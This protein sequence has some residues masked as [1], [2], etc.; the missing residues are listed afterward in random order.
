MRPP[1]E[2]TEEG[3]MPLDGPA[4][5]PL[6]VTPGTSPPSDPAGGSR[7]QV[8]DCRVAGRSP[9]MVSD[10]EHPGYCPNCG[11]SWALD[12]GSG[13]AQPVE[14]EASR[15]PIASDEVLREAAV[16]MVSPPQWILDEQ[17]ADSRFD[18]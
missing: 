11:H 15:Y 1:N 17:A 3:V 8:C 2:P 14:P 10:S 5:R 9:D 7:H 13:L 4:V 12:D 6:R 18:S 16:G